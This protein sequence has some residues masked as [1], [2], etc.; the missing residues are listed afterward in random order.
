MESRQIRD[1]FGM[2]K[3]DLTMNNYPG[4]PPGRAN[5][6]LR[7]HLDTIQDLRS[8]GYSVTG[9]LQVLKSMGFD[10]SRAT[11]GREFGRLA[12]ETS[13]HKNEHAVMASKFDASEGSTVRPEES[14]Q[15]KTEMSV[16]EIRREVTEFFNKHNDNPLFNRKK[17]SPSNS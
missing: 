9:A 12:K 11:V 16:Q 17:A 15:P 7:A 8:K 2:N 4:F 3:N 1:V 10:V 6:K 14:I 5:R 13:H